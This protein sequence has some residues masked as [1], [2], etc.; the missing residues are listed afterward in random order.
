[1]HEAAAVQSMFSTTVEHAQAAGA[2]R[3]TRIELT[4]GASDHFTEDVVRQHFEALASGTLAEGA[5]LDI[6]WLPA[7]YQC[8]SCLSRFQSV[9][10]SDS[11]TCPT[12]SGI[13]L[14]IAHEDVC[15]V[16]SIDVE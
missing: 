2:K 16:T 15:G 10:Q 7:T 9:D 1:M 3:I 14:E 6:T 5:L 8:F 11:V 12:C 4:L 13:A